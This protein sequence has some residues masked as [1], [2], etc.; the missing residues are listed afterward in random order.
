M[1]PYLDRPYPIALAH[2]G[3]I[4]V[5]EENSM[6][7]FT[8]A[9]EQL[10]F[11]YLETDTHATKDGVLVAFHDDRL[12]RVTDH[13]GKIA[14]FTWASLKKV[15]MANGDRIPLLEDLMT[16]WPDVCL[17]IDPKVDAAAER[18]PGVIRRPN[19]GLDRL[20]IGAFSVR[21]LQSLRKA[22]G[23]DLCTSMGP[24]EV[25]RL[26]LRSWGLP[27]SRYA[28][29]CCQ[30]P[31]SERGVPVADKR[32]IDA[33]HRLGLKVHVWTINEENEM[34]RLLDLGVDGLITDRPTLLK[35][36]LESRGQWSS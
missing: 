27:F 31:V 35:Q 3:G 32:F 28:A 14:D 17:N 5:A 4:E 2:R 15:R 12:D 25:L 29:Q 20:C 7:A 16:A 13:V 23:P 1:H 6:A 8:H 26:R 10:G 18:L 22:L 19:F 33:A 36:V 9:V 24:W 34:R 30:V 11:R 21:R